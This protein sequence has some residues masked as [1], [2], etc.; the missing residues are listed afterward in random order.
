MLRN[1]HITGTRWEIRGRDAHWK[2][3]LVV[4]TNLVLDPGS[5]DYRGEA[6]AELLD[7]VSDF[8]KLHPS[9]IDAVNIRSTRPDSV[10]F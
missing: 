5:S 6:E 9:M 7:A 2:R 8:W 4:M 1:E 10:T 3:T